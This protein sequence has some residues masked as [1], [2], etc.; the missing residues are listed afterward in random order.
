MRCCSC[1]ID[2]VDESR[3]MCDECLHDCWELDHRD[4]FGPNDDEPEDEE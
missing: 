2:T 1:G 4:D 3:D